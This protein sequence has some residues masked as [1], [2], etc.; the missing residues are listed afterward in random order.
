[1]KITGKFKDYF[2]FEKRLN[3]NLMPTKIKFNDI[4]NLILL[5]ICVFLDFLLM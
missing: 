5:T 2:G 3:E 4:M 1:M